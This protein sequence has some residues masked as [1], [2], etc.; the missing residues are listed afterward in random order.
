[1]QDPEN[2]SAPPSGP[3]EAASKPLI[4]IPVTAE[5]VARVRR[6]RTLKWL[7]VALVVLVAGW[8]VYKRIAD[9]RNARE[10]FDAGMRL[11]TATRYDQAILNFNR[12]VDLQPDFAEA[13]RMRGRAYVA[14]SNPDQAIRDFTRLAELR[15][16]DALALAERGFARLDKKDYVNAIADAD[17]AIAI[18]PKLARAYNLRGTA[19]R[20]AGDPRKAVEDFTKAVELEPD[21]DNYF[22][23][24]STYQ[25]IGNYQKAIAD[26][27][28][29]LEED[30]Q[31]PHTYY[32][33]AESKAAAGD[34]A[35]AAADVAA[36]H[37]LDGL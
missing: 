1:M 11:V 10:A 12:T 37:K 14:E 35:G 31:Q 29:A 21:L 13:Y 7:A 32:A 22:Q 16:R 24:A 5:D 20:E 8:I 36:G 28:K 34:K 4:L 3:A 33:R 27:D 26:F 18:D 6:S 19:R 2:K 9:P 17:R 15:P 30:P 23:R 25:L